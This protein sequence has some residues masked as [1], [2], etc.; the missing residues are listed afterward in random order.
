MN[1]KSIE[2]HDYKS[3]D[4]SILD[5]KLNNKLDNKFEL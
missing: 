3:Y 1:R 5:N 4:Y 2:L